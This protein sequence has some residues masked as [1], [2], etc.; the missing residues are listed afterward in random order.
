MLFPNCIAIYQ[1]K[2]YF[3]QLKEILEKGRISAYNAD[4]LLIEQVSVILYFY[5]KKLNYE[6]IVEEYYLPRFKSIYP[7]DLKDLK[8]KIN[9]FKLKEFYKYE[10]MEHNLINEIIENVLIENLEISEFN[11]TGDV[12]PFAELCKIVDLLLNNG[13]NEIKHHYLPL[14]DKSIQETKT[15]YEEDR[16]DNLELIRIFQF[17]EN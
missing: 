3:E 13:I 10:P 15:F 12:P 16:K 1:H 2:S 14:P 7:I 17:S 6:H 11:T 4:I 8:L 9:R 5:Y